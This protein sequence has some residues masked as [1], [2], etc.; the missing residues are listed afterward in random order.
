MLREKLRARNVRFY[1]PEDNPAPIL[2][3]FVDDEKTFGRKMRE[4]DIFVSAKQWKGRNIRISP[5]F[6]NNEEDIE[7]FLKAFD[8]ITKG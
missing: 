4:R 5:H 2:A 8:S 7:T 1:S 6:Y 3:F